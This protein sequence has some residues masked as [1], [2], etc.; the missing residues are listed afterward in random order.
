MIIVVGS[1]NMDLVIRTPRL[2]L[3]GE[4]LSGGPFATYPGGKGANQAVAAAR[5]GAAVTMVGRV[6]DDAFG[7]EL[8]AGLIHAGIDA[9][10][11]LATPGAATGV[12]LITV[13]QG[14]QNTIV[15]APGANAA[16]GPADIEA[17]AGA[18]GAART[19][20][21]QLEI[22]LP[23]ITRAAQIARAA[24]ATVILN[25]APA[26]A[27]PLPAELLACVD[28]LIPNEIE[29]AALLGAPLPGD[30][31]AAARAIRERTGVGA[32][33][34]TLGARGAAVASADLAYAQPAFPVDAV[35]A[36]A[37][38][39][40]FIGGF[41]AALAGGRRPAEALRW[42]CA[43]GALAATRMGAQASLP[44][45]SELHGLLGKPG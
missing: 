12:A 27:G 25:P 39:D 36:T 43:A 11:V 10:Q 4:T 40:A 22:P 6:G 14:G 8:R 7:G 13:E 45:L 32:A 9:A 23:A 42:G 19:L 34:I 29:A 15:I 21:L 24:G 3:P 26:P 2:P 20:L 33:L 37:A 35:D 38:G 44:N 16:V 28:Y 31:L 41:A 17:A 1:L 30:P 18:I 5:L